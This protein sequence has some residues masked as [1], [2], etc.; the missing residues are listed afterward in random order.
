[1]IPKIDLD[2]Q[3]LSTFSGRSVFESSSDLTENAATFEFTFGL[4]SDAKIQ[5]EIHH[6]YSEIYHCRIVTNDY[7]DLSDDVYRIRKL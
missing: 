2:C 4:N 7:N 1:M 3:D 6:E 5:A